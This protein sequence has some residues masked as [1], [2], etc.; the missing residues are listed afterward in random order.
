MSDFPIP[1]RVV[2]A[3]SQPFE[4]ETLQYLP[5]PRG[6][7]TF[8]MP[9]VPER[10]DA[11]ALANA[12]DLLAGFLAALEAWNPAVAPQGP[13]LDLSN[14]R[15]AVQEIVNEMLGEGEVSIRIGGAQAF[16]IQ[17]S[18]FTGLWRVCAL[19]A[20]G[21]LVGDWLEAAALPQIAVESARGA[22][23]SRLPRIELPEGAMNAPALLAEIGSQAATRAATRA[24]GRAPPRSAHVI[25]LTLFP[26]TPADHAV[27][28][29][30]LPVGPVA[31][32]SRGF[33]NCHVTSTGAADVWRVQ[34]FNNMN[35]LILN[36][37]EIVDV[38]EVVEAAVEDLT[39]SRER[40]CELVAWMTDSC[41][42]HVAS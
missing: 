10:A 9:I 20:D 33:G 24:A 3:D 34:Y 19:D 38:P 37:I 42:A 35:T 31:M 18:V 21:R 6:M 22:G 40:L 27:L 12:R 23:C 2:G 32:I 29:Q 41:D 16:R 30:A 8:Q 36:T 14:V 11:S 15:A 7:N 5:M 28:E 26:M 1:V 13:R 25:N 17:E 39:D 4:D